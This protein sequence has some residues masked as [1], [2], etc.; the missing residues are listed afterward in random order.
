MATVKV[1]IA[2]ARDEYLS[3]LELAGHKMFPNLEA[4]T[5]TLRAVNS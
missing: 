5:G 4:A 2:E 3:H 1:K